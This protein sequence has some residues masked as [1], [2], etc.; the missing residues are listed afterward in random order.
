[1]K[2]AAHNRWSEGQSQARATDFL[3]VLLGVAPAELVWD[4][5]H[6]LQGHAHI[7]S[8][9]LILIAAR[10]KAHSPVV[11]TAE[12]WDEIRHTPG[13]QASELVQRRAI[14]DH[15]KLLALVS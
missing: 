6:H 14:R 7:G 15:R 1:M 2:I 8:R 4:Q 12:D 13:E 5:T 11:L 10:D 9:E 3:K